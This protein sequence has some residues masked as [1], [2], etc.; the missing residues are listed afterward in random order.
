[1]HPSRRLPPALA[2]ALLVLCLVPVAAL[3]AGPASVTVRVEGVNE[4]LLGATPVTTS[5][6]PVVKDGNPHDACSGTSALGALA[7]ATS[8]NWSGKWEAS[9]HQYFVEAIEGETQLY[10]PGVTSYYWSFWLNDRFEETGPCEVQ[11]EAG[12][13]VLFFPLCDEA[14]PTG[15]APTPL[16]IAVPA[17]AQ[18]GEEV[19]AIVSRYDEAGEASPAAGARIAW[20]GGSATASAQGDATL[21]FTATGSLALS[22]NEPSSGPA[23]VRTE[24]V[25]CVHNGDDGSCGT[26]RPSTIHGISPAGG[27][28]KPEATPV[29]ATAPYK[30]PY[31]LVADVLDIAN[32]HTYPAARAPRVISG[33]ILSHSAVNAV[34]LELRR[35]YRGRCYSY[36]GTRER[37][38][39]A[40][41]G[42]ASVFTVSSDASFSYLLP[43]RLKPGRYVLDVHAGDVAGNITTL[44]RGSSRLVFHVR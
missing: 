26:P 21:R 22:V 4:T 36:D 17:R 14:C 8:G 20:N 1:M 28:S 25:V 23:A 11:L 33:K 5:E 30:G 27:S 12:D 44:A 18:E 24:A 29:A 15:A 16:E 32:G 6:E 41:C 13:R 2:L 31:A 37:F 34:T 3:G 40:R 38:V 10:Q 39:R 42:N 35:E 19:T 9:F 43:E 7:L